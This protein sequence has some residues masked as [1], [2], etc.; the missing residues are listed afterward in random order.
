MGSAHDDTCAREHGAS[1]F[2]QECDQ[3]GP[4][5]LSG[6]VT[7]GLAT[8]AVA[9]AS[10]SSGK[11][12]QRFDPGRLYARGPMPSASFC[13]SVDSPMLPRLAAF[14]SVKATPGFLA[15]DMESVSGRRRSPLVPRCRKAA[16]ERQAIWRWMLGVVGIG[17]LDSLGFAWF[18]WRRQTKEWLERLSIIP[19]GFAKK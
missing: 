17:S 9:Q 16:L 3:T 18:A 6:V 19:S 7:P 4:S 8:T 14:L 10:K 11:I 1:R 2:D 13:L 5:V 15:V 12:C